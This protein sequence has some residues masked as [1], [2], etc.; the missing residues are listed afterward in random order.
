MLP[1]RG[2]LG[3]EK[4]IQGV[5]TLK[6]YDPLFHINIRYDFPAVGDD[7]YSANPSDASIAQTTFNDNG[8]YGK[9]N[10]HNLILTIS[11]NSQF[12]D[13]GEKTEED[14]TGRWF[15]NV[16][17]DA[18]TAGVSAGASAVANAGANAINSGRNRRNNG[19]N[20]GRNNRRNN[21]RLG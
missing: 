17:G 2:F 21:R 12:F 8:K 14:S 11:E 18:V 7:T 19:R 4:G 15:S 20:N 9:D 6:C 1:E 5:A 13:E 10:P 16:A 3:I